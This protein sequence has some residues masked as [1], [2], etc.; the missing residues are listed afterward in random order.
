[1]SIIRRVAPVLAEAV[2]IAAC[3][4]VAL[5]AWAGDELLDERERRRYSRRKEGV[6]RFGPRF[7]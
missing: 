2:I 5:V 4:A 7:R 3:T 1:M 6:M